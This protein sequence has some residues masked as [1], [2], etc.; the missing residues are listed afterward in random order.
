MGVSEGVGH[1]NR[2]RG[3]WEGGGGAAVDACPSFKLQANNCEVG[4]CKE[5]VLPGFS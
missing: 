5:F 4:L 3:D 2:A 1:A